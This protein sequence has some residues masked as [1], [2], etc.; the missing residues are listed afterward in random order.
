MIEK[1]KGKTEMV[2]EFVIKD[3]HGNIKDQ[4][5]EKIEEVKK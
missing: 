2:I 1:V 5:T 4:G 3:K